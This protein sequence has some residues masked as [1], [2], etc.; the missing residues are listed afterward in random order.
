MDALDQDIS[1]QFFKF[2]ILGSSKHTIL[3]TEIEKQSLISLLLHARAP[4]ITM[5]ETENFML[6]YII[7]VTGLSPKSISAATFIRGLP[8]APGFVSL[9]LLVCPQ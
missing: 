5:M 1:L 7:I 2:I 8:I 6:C 9:N 4:Q 3:G